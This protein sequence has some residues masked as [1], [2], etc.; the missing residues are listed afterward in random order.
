MS[1]GDSWLAHSVFCLCFDC[2]PACNQSPLTWSVNANWTTID[3]GVKWKPECFW[4][5]NLVPWCQNAAYI[6]KNLS[7]EI[8]VCHMSFGTKYQYQIPIYYQELYLNHSTSCI[9]TNCCGG[10]NWGAKSILGV[11]IGYNGMGWHRSHLERDKVKV[12]KMSWF[13][14]SV[15]LFLTRCHEMWPS[16]WKDSSG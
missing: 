9:Y 1:P 12:W 6:W 3:Y 16:V 10:K 2:L 5:Q 14:S 11:I 8:T 15:I 13:L 4:Y 7:I